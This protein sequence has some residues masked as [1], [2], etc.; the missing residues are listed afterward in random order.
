[1]YTQNFETKTVFQ[2]RKNIALKEAWGIALDIGYSAVKGI[3]PNRIF[4]FP[5]FA[6]K[7]TGQ[8]L[9]MGTASPYEIQ[10][11]DENGETWNVGY[12]ALSSISSDD[13][14]DSINS[15]Y[16]RNRYFSPM[17]LVL[18]RTG[19]GVGMMENE[20][21]QAEGKPIALQTGLPP[22][23]LEEDAPYLK[24]A[25]MGNHRF[26]LRIGGGK[27]QKFNFT[28]NEQNI[29]VMPQPMGSLYSAALDNQCGQV[30]EAGKYF[31]SNLLIL[32]AGFGTVDIFNIRR[33][34]IIPPSV[35]FDD[36]GM[37]AVF[38]EASDKIYQKFHTRLQVHTMQKQL[39]QGFV[40]TFNRRTM[41]TKEEPFDDIL[42]ESCQ[43]VCEEALERMKTMYNNLLD[44][45][46][47]IVT[48]GTGAAWFDQIR[49]H[50]S[51][52]KS[53]HVIQANQND[54]LSPI[55]SNV[56]GYYLFQIGSLKR[57]NK[58]K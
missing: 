5:S 31:S 51:G 56:R 1:M 40:Q 55:F 34:Q 38:M 46:Y 41:T 13:N 14:N 35:S 9:N 43:N 19:I 10:Y 28:L 6:R 22:A 54:N 45:N 4:S 27:W 15:L 7:F 44:Y 8:Y 29:R 42:K 36:L 3:S 16:G 39:H 25:L 11:R 58:E 53:L 50:F 24:E 49:D 33:R 57:K 23:Y 47:L 37:K 2:N 21:G 32:D 48:G 17:F 12:S 52:M 30:P 20:F 26:S 18:A